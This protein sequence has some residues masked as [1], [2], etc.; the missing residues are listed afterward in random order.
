MTKR[1]LQLF[2]Q[3]LSYHFIAALFSL[4]KMAASHYSIPSKDRKNDYIVSLP[5]S[6]IDRYIPFNATRLVLSII[7]LALVA[8]DIPRSG[9]GIQHLNGWLDQLMPD[10]AMYFGPFTFHIAQIIRLPT[11][12]PASNSTQAY[13][14]QGYANNTTIMSTALWSYKFDGMSLAQRALAEALNVSSYPPCILY[15]GNCP[16]DR[17]SLNTTFIML[18]GLV[19]AIH[20]TYFPKLEIGQTALPIGYRTTS[21]WVDRLHHYLMKL[22]GHKRSE[23]RLHAVYFYRVVNNQT[24]NVCDQNVRNGHRP[25]FCDIPIKWSCPTLAGS[26]IAWSSS[27]RISIAVHLMARLARL[28]RQYPHLQFDVTL[29]TTQ[30]VNSNN[31][32]RVPIATSLILVK[33]NGVTTLI[34]GRSCPQQLSNSS[35]G[36]CETIVIDDYRYQREIVTTDVTRWYGITSSVRILSQGYVWV[37]VVFLWCGCYLARSREQKF[38]HSNFFSRVWSAWVTFFKIPSH[39]IVY[40]N[41]MPGIGYALGY[42]I[43]CNIGHLHIDNVFAAVNGTY[44]FDFWTFLR[45]ACVQMRNIWII[46]L[47]F[48]CLTFIEAYGLV[49]RSNRWKL[50]H[51]L[52]TFR[53]HLI[54]CLSALTI[55]APMRMLAFRT[56]KITFVEILPAAVLVNENSMSTMSDLI[57]EFGFRLDIKSVFEAC[58]LTIMGKLLVRLLIWAYMFTQRSQSMTKSPSMSLIFCRSHYLPYSIGTLTSCTT[59]SIFWSIYLTDVNQKVTWARKTASISRGL[60][61]ISSGRKIFAGLSSAEESIDTVFRFEH[62]SNSH[63][64]HDTHPRPP[65]CVICM[66][67]KAPLWPTVRGCPHHEYIY[68]IEH[69]SKAIW[70]MVRI[71]NLALLTDPFTLFKIYFTGCTLYLYR[72]NFRPSIHNESTR[73]FTARVDN[74]EQRVE[75]LFLLPCNLEELLENAMVEQ[76][77]SSTKYELIDTV[78]SADVPWSLLMMCG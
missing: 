18:D 53:G 62:N 32:Q 43:D 17:L 59:M 39:M 6:N 60:A 24:I 11:L 46:A 4:V 7:S 3:A 67:G 72:T 9:L 77:H 69:R 63:S 19:N 73:V 47:V 58:V 76:D 25:F 12:L 51:G 44:T 56:S 42:F 70:S 41:W 34:R 22:V 38:L 54:G 48:K 26:D 36:L 71:V 10:T 5:L 68:Q 14:Y 65:N 15:N 20:Q 78:D 37:R 23:S 8:S 49:P 74:A 52:R 31:D 61:W 35:N 2:C 13:E 33:K 64:A 40:G 50:R 75:S 55:F 57:S 66:D 45:A 16:S 28:Q 1:F 21:Y 29:F 30:M 27:N